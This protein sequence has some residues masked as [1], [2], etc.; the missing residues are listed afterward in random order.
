MK[1]LVISA[2]FYFSSTAVAAPQ[3]LYS[4]PSQQ[5]VTLEEALGSVLPGSVVIMGESH[6][7]GLHQSQQM[8]V[9]RKLREQG[10]KVSVGM[11][12]FSYVHQD[13]VD[14]YREGGLAESDFLQLIEWGSIDYAFYRDQVLFPVLSLGEQTLALNAPRAL[15]SRVGKSGLESLKAE[16]RALLPPHFTMGRGAYRQR[17]EETLPHVLPPEALERY[18]TA[19]SIWDDTM[20]WRAQEFLVNHP[21]Q[22]LVIIVGE[23]H[24]QYGGGL[25]DRLRARGVQNVL[26]FSQIDTTGAPDQDLNL[27]LTPSLRDGIRADFL[28]LSAVPSGP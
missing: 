8:A 24:V 2:F 7:S 18:F 17:F 14:F 20:A 6:G 16:E 4:G 9:L 22:V 23:F 12:F 5:A 19:Q 15:T 13:L 27:F 28:W 1:R 26:T 25:P 3:G 11:E 10:L 21:D